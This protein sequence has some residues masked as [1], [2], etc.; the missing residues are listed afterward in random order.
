AALA[1]TGA[2]HAAF[3]DFVGSAASNEGGVADGTVIVYDGVSVTFSSGG[4]ASFY[5][6]FDDLFD[7]RPAGLGVCE[8]LAGAPPSDCLDAGDDNVESGESVRV[9]FDRTVNLSN[10]SFSGDEHF[11]LNASTGTLLINGAAFTFI[12]VV[13][14]TPAV[15]A[16]VSGVT[17]VDFAFGGANP[18]AFYVNSFTASEV[19][20]PAAAP[21]LLAGLGGLSLASRRKKRG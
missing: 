10:F 21:L 11:S 17:F 4:P 12:D 8:T 1:A 15:V 13:G 2:A 6:Y 9:A 5:A 20:L 3:L 14:L 7:G 18:L 16:A 19:P